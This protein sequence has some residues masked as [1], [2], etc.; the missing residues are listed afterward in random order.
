MHRFA[1]SADIRAGAAAETVLAR[2][3]QLTFSGDALESFPWVL[4]AILVIGTV[5]RK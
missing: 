2:V 4:D 5:G 1:S 3:F